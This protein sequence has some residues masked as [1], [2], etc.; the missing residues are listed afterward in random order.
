MI[1]DYR[2]DNYHKK[3]KYSYSCAQKD[4][5]PPPPT[6]KRRQRRAKLGKGKEGKGKKKKRCTAVGRLSRDMRKEMAEYN[7]LKGIEKLGTL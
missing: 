4:V 7:P 1:I 5:S 3:V 6:A 2:P